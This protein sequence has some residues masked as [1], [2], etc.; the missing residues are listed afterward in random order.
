MFVDV[1]LED[2]EVML[3]KI[4]TEHVATVSVKFFTFKK[5]YYHFDNICDIDK[6][7][8][9]GFYDTT[10]TIESLGYQEISNNRYILSDDYEPSDTSEQSEE[11]ESYY[12]ESELSDDESESIPNNSAIAA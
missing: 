3:A 6:E 1:L 7:C 10:E 5:N 8:I 12:T 2:D 4:V 11:S 9:C